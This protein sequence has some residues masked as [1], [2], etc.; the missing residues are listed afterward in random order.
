M[1]NELNSIRAELEQYKL[2]EKEQQFEKLLQSL[3]VGMKRNEEE[4]AGIK[5]MFETNPAELVFTV[6]EHVNNSHC[7]EVAGEK[8][9]F[10]ES[11]QC[12]FTTVGDLTKI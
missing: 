8:Y 3:P 1:V 2:K 5:N 11:T 10:S 12:K 9:T 4:I 7:T 6:L